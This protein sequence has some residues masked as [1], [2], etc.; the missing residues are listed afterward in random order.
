M[1]GR[2]QEKGFVITEEFVII[3]ISRL[4]IPLPW[5]ISRAEISLFRKGLE[6]SDGYDDRFIIYRDDSTHWMTSIALSKEIFFQVK[7]VVIIIRVKFRVII[8]IVLYKNSIIAKI[9]FYNVLVTI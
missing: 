5:M 9:L 1:Q 6:F 4:Y 3:F 7:N 2:R 8:R